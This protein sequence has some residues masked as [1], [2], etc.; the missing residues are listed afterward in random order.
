MK[1]ILYEIFIVIGCFVRIVV[2]F[3][4]VWVCVLEGVF[5]RREKIYIE[6]ICFCIIVGRVF[7]KKGIV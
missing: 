3:N 7:I 6:S 1:D 2:D 5:G 4:D